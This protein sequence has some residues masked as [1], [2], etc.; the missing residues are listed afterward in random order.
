MAIQKVCDACGF[1]ESSRDARS[2]AR[3]HV[4]NYMDWLARRSE[5]NEERSP[6]FDLCPNC[7]SRV[8]EL[9]RLFSIKGEGA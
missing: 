8:Q 5:D 4:P 7:F 9:L 6:E 2:W 1:T 3:L